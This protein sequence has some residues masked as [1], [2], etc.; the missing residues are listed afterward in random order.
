MVLT[1]RVVVWSF[2]PCPEA[3]NY[4]TGNP[5]CIPMYDDIIGVVFGGALDNYSPSSSLASP[6]GLKG[7]PVAE[8]GLPLGLEPST[9]PTWWI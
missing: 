8:D 6:D 4:D 5:F 1:I 7:P 3:E 2:V 9:V